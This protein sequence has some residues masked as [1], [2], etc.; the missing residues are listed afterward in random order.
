MNRKLQNSL[1]S[2]AIAM[3]AGFSVTSFMFNS[4]DWMKNHRAI[5]TASA[6]V[7]ILTF[8]GSKFV[9]DR[10]EVPQILIKEAIATELLLRLSDSTLKQDERDALQTS[11]AVFQFDCDRIREQ[12]R[13]H[14]TTLNQL[15]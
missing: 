9:L 8:A 2:G 3:M 15:L 6:G 4:L 11:L 13:V 14:V 10:R 12:S 7:G 5:A 1:V